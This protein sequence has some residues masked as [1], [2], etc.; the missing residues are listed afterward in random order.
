MQCVGD[1]M[2]RGYESVGSSQ[3]LVWALVKEWQERWQESESFAPGHH[4]AATNS[5]LDLFRDLLRDILKIL[6]SC[7]EIMSR[8]YRYC[9]A[10]R[11]KV[12]YC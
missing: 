11:L 2:A 5:S 7:L 4:S 10:I 6:V 12:T 9:I 8:I 1:V 3:N